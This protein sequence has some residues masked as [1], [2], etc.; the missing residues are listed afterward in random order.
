MISII[1]GSFLAILILTVWYA[2]ESEGDDDAD[3]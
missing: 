2:I 1:W 3:K